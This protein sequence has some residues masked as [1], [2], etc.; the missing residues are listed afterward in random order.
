MQELS[1]VGLSPD[2]RHL[3]LVAPD[4]AEFALRIDD[5]LASA[6]RRE[7]ER[8]RGQPTDLGP[9]PLNPTPREIQERIRAGMSVG[10]IAEAAGVDE[11]SVARFATA[12]LAERAFVANQA[13]NTVIRFQETNVS[14]ADAVATRLGAN[15]IDST[16][17]RWDAWRRVDGDWTIVCAYP[18]D[19]GERIATFGYDPA[20]SRVWPD[21]D[22]ARWIAER[23][24]HEPHPSVASQASRELGPSHHVETAASQRPTSW[25]PA[26]PATRAHQRRTHEAG[27]Q[28]RPV[29][30]ASRPGNAESSSHPADWERLLLGEG[31]RI[32]DGNDE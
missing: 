9:M 25:D 11:A 30:E 6:L 28:S 10:A 22:A 16:A 15:G 31:G 4:A 2:G 5:R 14:L 12:V 29:P 32:S 26:H 24:A 1:F 7:S 27:P 18:F 3:V 23:P 8:L 19:R 13:A 20:D 21:D 17:V